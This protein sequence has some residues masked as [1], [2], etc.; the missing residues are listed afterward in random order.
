MEAFRDRAQAGMTKEGE[1][2]GPDSKHDKEAEGN[3]LWCLE[4][5]LFGCHTRHMRR[6][7]RPPEDCFVAR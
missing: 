7:P 5:R 2:D 6:L 4:A 3:I 1:E